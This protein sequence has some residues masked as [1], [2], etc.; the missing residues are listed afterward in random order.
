M[1]HWFRKHTKEG[2]ETPDPTPIEITMRNKPLTIAEQLQRFATNEEIKE[3]LR[4]RNVD[5]FDEA[6]DFD[7]PGMEPDE[8]RTPYEDQF[9]GSTM[10][11]NGIQA[12]LDEQ[13]AG[14]T[15]EMPIERV[16]RAKEALRPKAKVPQVP[17]QTAASNVKAEIN[18]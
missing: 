18:G 7:I 10:R 16:E 8:F 15:E 13:K 1:F 6:D 5:T 12:R 4:Q 3:R 14:M 9:I 11:F 2:L 17:A